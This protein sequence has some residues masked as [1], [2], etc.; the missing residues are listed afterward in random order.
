M[1]PPLPNNGAVRDPL[2]LPGFLPLVVGNNFQETY[3][4]SKLKRSYS[5]S[6]IE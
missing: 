2:I 5:G 1:L 4:D 6:G 3:D